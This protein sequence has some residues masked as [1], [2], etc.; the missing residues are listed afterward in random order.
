MALIN[1]G[2]GVDPLTS[3][4]LITASNPVPVAPIANAASFFFGAQPCSTANHGTFVAPATPADDTDR[5]CPN[6][7][8]TGDAFAEMIGEVIGNITVQTIPV[9]NSS[10]LGDSPTVESALDQNQ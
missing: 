10:V 6:G 3:G 9:T 8:N 7:S 2:A 1:L 4:S 5:I